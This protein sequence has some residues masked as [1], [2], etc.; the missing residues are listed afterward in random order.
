MIAVNS[1]L[2]VKFPAIT[3]SFSIVFYPLAGSQR[4]VVQLT[5]DDAISDNSIQFNVTFPCQLSL[6]SDEISGVLHL[7]DI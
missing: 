6:S 7:D 1:A 5:S 3:T 4:W 2:G